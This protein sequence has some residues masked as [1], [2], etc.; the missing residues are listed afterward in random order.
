[1]KKALTCLTA[2]ALILSLAACGEEP[3]ETSSAAPTKPPV[4]GPVSASDT[5][6][7]ASLPEPTVAP[8]PTI[9]NLALSAEAFCDDNPNHVDGVEYAANL[10]NDGDVTTAWQKDGNMNAGD[11][12]TWVA[13]EI[14]GKGAEVFIG[15]SWEEEQSIAKLVVVNDPGNIMETYEKGG[16]KLYWLDTDKDWV[17]IEELTDTRSAD[18]GKATITFD[19]VTTTQ[20]R[21]D[22]I[23]GVAQSKYSPKVYELEAYAPEVTE[24]PAESEVTE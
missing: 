3:A 18:G 14:Y 13:E 8:K 2:L 15:L 16:F 11:G 9:V 12:N 6:S 10:A 17:E 23:R 21:L 7:S 24:E 5:S 4:I 1:M 19:A 20:I 22:M